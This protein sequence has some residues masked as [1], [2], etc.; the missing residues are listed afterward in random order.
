MIKDIVANKIK[1]SDFDLIISTPA[2]MTKLASIARI[3]GPLG[4]MPNPKSGTVV[5]PAKLSKSIATFKKGRDIF[6]TP[7]LIAIKG[8]AAGIVNKGFCHLLKPF[9][10]PTN[11]HLYLSTC[12]H[13]KNFEFVYQER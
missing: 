11:K 13:S 7:A 12:F 6:V 10:H 2:T 3:L 1:T 4:L 8:N 9:L 5:D